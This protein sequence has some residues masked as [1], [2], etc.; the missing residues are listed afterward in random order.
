VFYISTFKCLFWG[1][2]CLPAAKLRFKTIKDKPTKY[3]GDC[4][5]SAPEKPGNSVL[6]CIQTSPFPS[7][8]SIEVET[9]QYLLA[10][11]NTTVAQKET[12]KWHYMG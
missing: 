7:I 10:S 2:D 8:A 5:R 3:H 9:Y 12:S 1:L 6:S 11:G 4:P